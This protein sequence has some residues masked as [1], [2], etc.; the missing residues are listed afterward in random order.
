MDKDAD[1]LE[2]LRRNTPEAAEWLLDRFG[3][4]VYQLA[5]RITGLNTDAEEATQDALW[6]LV[7]EVHTFTGESTFASWI[8]R[9]TA[10]AAY[11]R[12]AARRHQIGEIWIDHVLPSLNGDGRHFDPMDDW[13][14]RL[15]QG[16][17]PDVLR[18]VLTEAIDAL[19]PDY[20]TA[21]VLHDREN[22][23]DPDIAH[24]MNISLAAARS[25]VHRSRL[26]VRKRLSEY[27]ESA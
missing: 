19:P 13:S 1:L 3:D 14:K 6:T 25:R 22:V 16:P 26:L 23:S 21:L 10:Q 20:R 27:L 4:R 11:R 8:D 12:L 2:A 15:G 17:L 24:V 18:Q 7:H 9:I 5:L